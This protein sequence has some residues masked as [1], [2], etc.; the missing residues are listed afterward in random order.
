MKIARVT[1][2]LRSLLRHLGEG[3]TWMGWVCWPYVWDEDPDKRPD[4]RESV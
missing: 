3:L 1:S 4:T 2:A